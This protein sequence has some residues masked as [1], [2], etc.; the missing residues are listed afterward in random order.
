MMPK[1]MHHHTMFT[2]D[3]MIEILFQMANYLPEGT[4]RALISSNINKNSL[5]KRPLEIRLSKTMHHTVSTDNIMIEI[6]FQKAF[7]CEEVHE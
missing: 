7:T 1:T 2:D 5:E 3:T 6:P 4:I